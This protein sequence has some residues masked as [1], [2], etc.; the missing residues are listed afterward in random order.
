MTRSD[1]LLEIAF[2][3]FFE[4]SIHWM[5]FKIVFG[6]SIYNFCLKAKMS[7]Y[8]QILEEK[9]FQEQ[10]DGGQVKEESG[11]PFHN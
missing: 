6:L 11:F 9:H 5:N 10:P 3:N 7:F 2:T 4:A 8:K 1:I